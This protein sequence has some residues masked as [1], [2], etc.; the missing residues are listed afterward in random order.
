MPN[1]LFNGDRNLKRD[2]E[3]QKLLPSANTIEVTAAG[4]DQAVETR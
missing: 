2:A 4:T 1:N 3:T